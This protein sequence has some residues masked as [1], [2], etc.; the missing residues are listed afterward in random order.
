MRFLL[1]LLPI[2]AAWIVLSLV[3]W[4]AMAR[5]Y[6]PHVRLM[7]PGDFT[8]DWDVLRFAPHP[9]LTRGAWLAVI[10]AGFSLSVWILARG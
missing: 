10:L 8:R 2:L 9:V 1:A 6:E 7:K 4:Y 5:H 3:R